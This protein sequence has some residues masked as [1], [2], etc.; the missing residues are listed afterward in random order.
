MSLSASP[1]RLPGRNPQIDTARFIA[2]LGV[3]CIHTVD[4]RVT[5]VLAEISRFAVPLF[6]CLS[7]Y[8]LSHS[9]HD[10][11][12]SSIKKSIIRIAPIYLFWWVIY[13]VLSII[14]GYDYYKYHSQ[15]EIFLSGGFGYHLWFLTALLFSTISF[16]IL[17][18]WFSLKTIFI[19]SIIAYIII[20]IFS[21]YNSISRIGASVD[22]RVTPFYGLPYLTAGALA[23][24]TSARLRWQTA[25]VLFVL[26]VGLNTGELALIKHLGGTG[27]K[28][29][30][31]DVRIA[32][33]PLGL[34]ALALTL[35]PWPLLRFENAMSRWGRITLGFYAI[36]LM[37]VI[38]MMKYG[39]SIIFP[40][41]LFPV[42]V[43]TLSVL[44]G[45]ICCKTYFRRFFM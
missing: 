15:I 16:L 1:E 21:T 6:F 5:F 18:R 33:L 31:P 35:S 42:S 7:G 25:L 41:V 23:A 39:V 11:L 4:D 37:W 43:A 2:F 45:S 34:A 19:V 32:T 26:A 17:K 14:L 40:S 3:V 29:G 36:H 9:P 27:I 30:I 20:T 13:F 22:V 24:R 8:F 38:I 12:S 28:G 44:S 10:S